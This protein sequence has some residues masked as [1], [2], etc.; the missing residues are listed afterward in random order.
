MSGSVTA[1]APSAAHQPAHVPEKVFR[2]VI[3]TTK[4]PLK[5]AGARRKATLCIAIPLQI[6]GTDLNGQ[7]FVEASYSER[8][9]RHG[10]FVRL[11]RFLGPEQQLV[12]RRVGARTE[13]TARVVGQVGIR[14]NGYVYGLEIA[15]THSKFWGV[16]FP[17][18]SDDVAATLI[19][20][21]CCMTRDSAELNEIEFAVLDA[22]GIL[23]WPCDECYAVTF[24]Q[25]VPDEE[26]G[27]NGSVS[28]KARETR[29]TKSNRRKMVRTLIKA[30]A[31][32]CQPTGLRDV[33]R[34]IDVS[35][36]GISFRTLQH[37]PIHSWVELAAPY[38]E[39]GANIF[40]PGRVVW[41]RP[42]SYGFKE[43]GVQ[44]VRN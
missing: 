8:V 37:Y 31:C 34:L 6:C 29:S 15:E 4:A 5:T 14:S 22:N 43:Y 21:S 36:G 40:V 42:A 41:E 10:A 7:D 30:S 1:K 2:G 24:W 13:I 3:R 39:G 32:L 38:T 35:R 33:A 11:N 18:A 25:A 44:Y 19:R 16:H 26:R 28:I 27:S 23:S 9:S 20:C 12:I 17:P